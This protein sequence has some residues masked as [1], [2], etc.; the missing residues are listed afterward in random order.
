MSKPLISLSNA[1]YYRTDTLKM[2]NSFADS[3]CVVNSTDMIVQRH[4]YYGLHFIII[5]YRLSISDWLRRVKT[6]RQKREEMNLSRIEQYQ[7][8]IV[9]RNPFA[10]KFLLCVLPYCRSHIMLALATRLT[11]PE[12]DHTL[13]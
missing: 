13:I 5:D 8:S 3:C 1:N 9:S 7:S 2:S 4:N 11:E 12:C 6:T 10:L